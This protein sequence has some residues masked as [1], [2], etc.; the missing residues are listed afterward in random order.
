M[1]AA[2]WWAEGVSDLECAVVVVPLL[3]RRD[4]LRD[5]PMLGNL[6]ALDSEKVIV[7]AR[8]VYHRSLA[9]ARTKF[10]SPRTKLEFVD[11][12]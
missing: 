12:E 7:D 6:P 1:K 3:L 4:V 8:L 5:S 11:L 2:A 10:P 9:A